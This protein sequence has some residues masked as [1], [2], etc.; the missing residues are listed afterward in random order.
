M[1][2]RYTCKFVREISNDRCV[3]RTWFVK[4]NCLFSPRALVSGIPAKAYFTPEN[5]ALLGHNEWI[6]LCRP[7]VRKNWSL[8]L[9]HYHLMAVPVYLMLISM[10]FVMI[11]S[12]W[13]TPLFQW[14]GIS[15]ASHCWHY[16]PGTLSCNQVSAT[17]LK[18][19]HPWMKF[20]SSVPGRFQFNLR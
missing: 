6:F 7:I 10:D 2:Q 9:L 17:H 16:C 1:P 11:L 8:D 18:I 4:E 14:L 12:W 19:R 5:M 13:P 3:E 15:L 20:N